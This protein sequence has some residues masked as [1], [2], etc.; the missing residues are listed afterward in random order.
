M[1]LFK[2]IREYQLATVR[3]DLTAGL[4]V[5]ILLIPQG[6]AYAMLAGLPPIYGLYAGFIPLLIYPFFGSSPQLSVGPVA[7]VSIIVLSGLSGFADPGSEEFIRLAILTAFIAGMIQVIL[8]IFKMGFLTNF[9]SEPVIAGFTMAAAIIIGLSQM[10]YILGLSIPRSTSVLETISQ[11]SAHVSQTNILSLVLGAGSLALILLIKKLRKSLPGALLVIIAG[12]LMVYY[13]GWY[14]SGLEIVGTVPEGLPRLDMSFFAPGDI[15]KVIPLAII[16]CII[17]FIESLS[18]SKTIAGK[19]EGQS[20]DA[21]KELMGLGLSKVVG[22]FFLGYPSTGSFTRS[23]V[24]NEAGAVTG[25]S[26]IFAAAVVG[27]TLIIFTPLFFY[28]PKPAL[29][30]GAKEIGLSSVELLNPDEWDIVLNKGL[31]CA[32]SFGSPLGINKGF[33]DPQYHEQ[34]RS[35]IIPIIHQAAEKGISQIICFSGNRGNISDEEGLENCAVGLEAVVK[36]AEKYD[37]MITM[38]LLNS[39]VN[40]PDYMCDHTEWG[41]ALVDKLGSSNFKLLYDIYH[42][43]IMEGDIIATIKKYHEYIAHYHTGGVPGRNE[44][45]ETQELYYPAI[46]RAIAETGYEGFVG[47]EFIPTRDLVLD[48]LQE[49]VH[50]CDI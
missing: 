8:A 13:F 40:H 22:S 5:A 17:S 12:T 50:I 23:A 32:I 43:Q 37:I 20:I 4:T 44:I 31:E 19:K 7:V 24:N 49:G 34:L 25:M 9:L 15:I 1:S 28:M 30:D 35:D 48:S 46:M 27:L 45:N 2:A 16:I 42:M 39:R 18:I 33:N 29:A 3:H 38:E 47:Q 26:S 11:L 21:N 41:V 14:D 6:M 36:E 10:K